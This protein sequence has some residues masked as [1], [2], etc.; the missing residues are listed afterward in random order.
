MTGP[1]VS[2]IIP[3]YNYG[4]LLIETLESV[5]YQTYTNWECIIIDDGSTDDTY[6]VVEIFL[7][8]HT[9]YNFKYLRLQNQGTSGAKN[10]GI[11]QAS[12][13]LIQFLD[14]DDL[15]SRDKLTI[16]VSLLQQKD[17]ALVF[18]A[19]RF[20]KRKNGET[21]IQQ[22]Y[23]DDFLAKDS[24]SEHAL[25]K[26][27]IVNN[28]VTISSPLVKA[29][30]VHKAG[31]FDLSLK[32]NEDWILWFNIAL[33]QPLFLCDQ[34]HRSYVDIRIH[35]RSAMN[36]QQQMFLGEVRVRDKMALLLQQQKIST[37][38]L[39]LQKLNTDLLALHQIRSLE[40]KK[41]FSYIISNFIKNPGANYTL[42]GKG[43]YKLMVRLYKTVIK[44]EN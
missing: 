8:E 11:D 14:A 18:S 40:I 35:R 44:N 27:L 25:L 9:D 4:H 19:S 24:L 12:G 41:G 39:A 17:A 20:F 38:N 1:L 23:P 7:S 33:I 2:I 29:S 3:T 42:L 26:K 32:N 6:A 22:R 34:D 10:A 43:C 37:K 16:Q 13:E 21:V 15:L 5:L 31:K 36:Q 28:V 30:L